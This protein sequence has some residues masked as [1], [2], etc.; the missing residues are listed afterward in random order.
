MD[1]LTPDTVRDAARDIMT[2]SNTM[3]CSVGALEVEAARRVA[4][5]V[6]GWMAHA[7]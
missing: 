7:C 1:G 3:I 4:L 6:A 2:T 5:S